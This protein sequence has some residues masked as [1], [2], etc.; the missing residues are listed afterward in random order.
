MLEPFPNAPS[1]TCPSPS[2]ATHPLKGPAALVPLVPI[3]TENQV[4][5]DMT[6]ELALK[7]NCPPTLQSRYAPCRPPAACRQSLARPGGGCQPADT[8]EVLGVSVCFFTCRDS[9]LA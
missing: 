5:N 9:G 2:R 3:T 4:A 7:A 6:W 1:P 8:G